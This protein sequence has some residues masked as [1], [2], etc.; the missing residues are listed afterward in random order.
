[1]KSPIMLSSSAVINRFSFCRHEVFLQTK[2]GVEAKSYEGMLV[3]FLSF[4]LSFFI[5][6]WYTVYHKLKAILHGDMF[7]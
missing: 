1:M 6:F 3:S 2:H 7:E 4:C 5:Y